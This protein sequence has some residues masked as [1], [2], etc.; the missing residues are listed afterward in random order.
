MT[1]DPNIE[2]KAE[3]GEQ[4]SHGFL[5]PALVNRLLAATHTERD[6]MQE[7]WEAASSAYLVCEAERDAARR[8]LADAEA[9]YAKVRELTRARVTALEADLAGAQETIVEMGGLLRVA[10][11][12]RRSLEADLDTAT[13]HNG[14]LA[15]SV[16]NLKVQVATL[17]RER[18]VWQA[19]AERQSAVNM[20]LVTDLAACR[21][22]IAEC[23]ENEPGGTA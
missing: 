21:I 4:C 14:R 10:G 20:Q 16:Q 9:D 11:D 23:H 15:M 1:H 7:R 18:D 12:E 13:N 22:I 17:E 3:P 2:V 19:E 6:T 8:T 5:A